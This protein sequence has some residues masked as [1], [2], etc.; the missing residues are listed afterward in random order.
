[1]NIKISTITQTNWELVIFVTHKK[2]ILCLWISARIAYK[3]SNDQEQKYI[4][5]NF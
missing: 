4:V 5:N 2:V 1:M 3:V